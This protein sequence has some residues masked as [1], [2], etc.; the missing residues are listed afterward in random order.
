MSEA[1]LGFMYMLSA[2]YRAIQIPNSEIIARVH[3]L[4]PQAH[5]RD[6]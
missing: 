2:F 6:W 4:N 1:W 5:N 3:I